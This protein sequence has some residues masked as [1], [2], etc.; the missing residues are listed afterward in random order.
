MIPLP[1]NNVIP[2]DI[3]MEI[4]LR[5]PLLSLNLFKSVSKH[6]LSLITSRHFTRR[7][8][9]RRIDPP[10]GLFIRRKDCQYYDF[11]TLGPKVSTSI[12]LQLGSHLNI[13]QSCNG[14]LLYRSSVS[15]TSPVY[16]YNPF[17]NLLKDIPPR[18]KSNNNDIILAFD[19]TKSPYYKLVNLT[20]CQQIQIYSSETGEWRIRRTLYPPGWFKGFR[21]GLYWN[22]AIHWINYDDKLHSKFDIVDHSTVTNMQTPALDKVDYRHTN[23][24][25]SRASLLLLM[26]DFSCR[27]HVFEMREESSEWSVKYILDDIINIVPWGRIQKSWRIQSSF[28]C[29]VLGEREDDSFMVIESH[30]N[31]VRYNFVSKTVSTLCNFIPSYLR[32]SRFPFIASLAG[33]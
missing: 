28:L 32:W 25:E 6:W 24:F 13:M 1:K 10:C 9:K 23:L 30:Y 8:L 7:L 27:C 5:L 17:T 18:P 31:I 3:W 33:V 11:V 4:F 2:D 16:V 20:F 14:L 12:T 29:I 22:N 15:D 19:P 26:K 21:K